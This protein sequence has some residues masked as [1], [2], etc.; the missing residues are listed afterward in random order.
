M[1]G[2]IE[3]RPVLVGSP[4]HAAELGHVPENH[5]TIQSLEE[6]GKTVVVVVE[7]DAGVRLKSVTMAI[8]KKKRKRR[9]F[10]FRKNV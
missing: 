4:R 8:R 2:R 6:L 10:M 7:D 1:T 3:G 5:P 9:C